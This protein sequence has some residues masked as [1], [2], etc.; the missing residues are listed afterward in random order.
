MR[1]LM[2]ATA[3]EETW[4]KDDTPVL[5]L[6]EWCRKY[7]R[8]KYWSNL[9]GEVLQY[10]WDDRA[11]LYNDYEYI[12]QFTESVLAELT[13][14]LNNIH[15]VNFTIRYWRI[16]IGPWLMEFICIIYDRWSNLKNAFKKYE[17]NSVNLVSHIDCD[18]IPLDEQ[19]FGEWAKND[20]WNNFIYSKLLSILKYKNCNYIVSNDSLKSEDQLIESPAKNNLKKCIDKVSRMLSSNGSYFIY[21]PYLNVCNNIL[22]H[23][24]LFQIPKFY[25]RHRINSIIPVKNMRNWEMDNKYNNIFEELVKKIIPEQIPK[26]YLEG[27]KI[28]K[29]KI[30]TIGYPKYPKLIWTTNAFHSDEVFKVWAAEKTEHGVPLVIGQHGGHY[31]QGLFSLQE[32][33]EIN[34]CDKYLTWGWSGKDKKIV[35]VGILKKKIKKRNKSK[36]LFS[37]LIISGTPRYSGIIFSAPMSKQYLDYQNDQFKFHAHLPYSIKRKIKIRLYHTDYDWN[38]FERWKNIF[39]ESIIDDCNKNYLTSI[40]NSKIVICGWNSTTYLESLALNIPTMMF[41]NLKLFELREDSLPY[42]NKLKDVGVFHE[43]PLSAAKHLTKIWDN[44]EL[45]WNSV[46][47]RNAR[48]NFV[49]K[50]CNNKKVLNNIK[51]TLTKVYKAR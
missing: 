26:I 10:H 5:F 18:N 37:H 21:Y 29:N 13:Q 46:E 35:P 30:N 48:K 9:N 20:L 7:N 50:Y 4:P 45:W 33:H 24:K 28:I 25:Y 51:N 40:I 19:Q 49:D 16:I 31:G 41:W 17:I 47:V 14:I 42:F 12:R 39:S 23:L 11:K 22:L 27:Y 8:K 36:K 32:N 1:R 2:V 44:I 38:Q 43:T 3:L 15:K 6:G 34:I